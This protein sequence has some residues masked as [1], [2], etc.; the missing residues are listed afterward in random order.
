MVCKAG[1]SRV[2]Q[3]P[4]R[5]RAGANAGWCHRLCTRRACGAAPCSPRKV[6]RGER[7]RTSGP[8]LPK[9]VLYQAELLPDRTG[10]RTA[11]E[12]RRV[13]L[14]GVC[15]GIKG[16]MRTFRR[17]A[18]ESG[19][20]PMEA[21]GRPMVETPAADPCRPLYMV[22]RA[23]GFSA[24]LARRLRRFRAGRPARSPAW[25]R[26]RDR[27]ARSPGRFR[28]SDNRRRPRPRIRPRTP[29]RRR[30]S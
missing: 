29:R 14:T 4:N 8:C 1:K 7:I 2:R 6:G 28:C 18:Q 10:R 3:R 22:Q 12:A 20:G 21:G 5:G 26:H 30:Q 11:P 25:Y 15:A 19:A 24:P 13:P 23:L 27:R 16:V 9:T 17:R